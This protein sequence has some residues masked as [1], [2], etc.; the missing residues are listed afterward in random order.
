MSF[1]VIAIA[2][3]YR[4]LL[5]LDLASIVAVFYCA[6]TWVPGRNVRD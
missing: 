3:D 5:F 4:Y 6:A 2:C 1:F